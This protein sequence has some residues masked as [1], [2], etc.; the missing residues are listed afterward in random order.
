MRI[1]CVLALDRFADFVSDQAGL[2]SFLF[3]CQAV[4]PSLKLSMF[5]SCYY[6]YVQCQQA[7]VHRLY[8][9]TN[10]IH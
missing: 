2:F 10:S 9:S 6:Q 5:R 8:M 7:P 1:V 3:R 4:Q